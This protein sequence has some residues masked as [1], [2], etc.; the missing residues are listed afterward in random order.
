MLDELMARQLRDVRLPDYYHSL[1]VR[2]QNLYGQDVLV[3]TVL[4]ISSDAFV[5]R[6][7][8]G[9]LYQ[10]KLLELKVHLK[11][12]S[13]QETG[14]DYFHCANSEIS[15]VPEEY[16]SLYELICKCYPQL[17][18]YSDIVRV[19]PTE[20]RSFRGVGRT[21]VDKLIRWQESI[22]ADEM[23]IVEES[24]D[25]SQL[26]RYRL[27]SFYFSKDEQRLFNKYEHSGMSSD[28]IT[29]RFIM[30]LKPREI[31]SHKGFGR[32]S[33][34]ALRS[35]Q[36]KIIAGLSENS[37]RGILIPTGFGKSLSLREIC[38]LLS[39]DFDQCLSSLDGEELEIWQ[40]RIAY[41]ADRLTL[42][43][44]GVRFGVTRERIR[45]KA[46]LCNQFLLRGIRV[47]SDV[48]AEKLSSVK[49]SDLLSAA[50][51]LRKNFNSD[52]ALISALALVANIDAKELMRQIK[53]SVR[54]SVLDSY[55]CI[56]PYPC[57]VEDAVGALQDE[58]GICED[59]AEVYLGALVEC[60]QLDIRGHKIIPKGLKKE[61]AIAHILTNYAQG[62]AWKEIAQK[63]NDSGICRT[64][65]SMERADPVLSYS[66]RFFQSD[67]RRYSHIKYFCPDKASVTNVLDDIKYK[68]ESSSYAAIHLR[69]EYY[70][71]LDNPAF[72]YFT[73]R[74]IA[75][76][77]GALKG[78]YFDGK[79]QKDTVSLTP[80]VDAVSQKSAI[81]RIL[82]EHPPMSIEEI[83]A[84]TRSGSESLALIYVSELRGEG[85]VILLENS[86][87]GTI[88]TAFAGIDVDKYL[89]VLRNMIFADNRIHHFN[90]LAPQINRLVGSDHSPRFYKSLASGYSKQL[91]I[92]VRGLL[93]SGSPIK[94]RGLTSLVREAPA[95]REEDLI[96]WLQQRVCASREILKRAI[97]NASYREENSPDEE[98][99]AENN[100]LA[101]DIMQEL[102]DL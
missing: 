35:L 102:F 61:T 19:S 5:R 70:A 32:K 84:R 6:H 17:K 51:V 101:S 12:S 29:P 26:D 97:L 82:Q 53:P 91:G 21:K 93:A 37:S 81:L 73:V 49:R 89:P 74:H 66:S 46:V 95:M 64:V 48:M 76:D 45:Q 4:D 27:S 58:L 28:E 83:A 3:R 54:L 36:K 40:H 77:F 43:E 23:N 8:V 60:G 88:E 90:S 31:Q 2:L 38:S 33:A 85:L 34:D 68:I 99:S 50:S 24:Y 78:I 1:V 75:R 42:Q 100:G 65:L 69:A 79:S 44:L 7:G 63:V 11:R 87:Y 9:A 22:V 96:A 47:C 39:E 56:T 94:Y 15:N 20:F 71:N 62:L 67:N 57:T 25:D 72:D 52:S 86:L 80:D 55:F 14:C 30:E 13:E 16:W 98:Q 10:S 59:E 92:H 18:T 41:K